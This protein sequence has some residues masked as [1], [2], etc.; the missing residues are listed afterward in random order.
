MTQPRSGQSDEVHLVWQGEYEQA[1]VVAAYT[2]ATDAEANVARDGG[3]VEGIELMEREPDWRPYFHAVA[4]VGTTG[5]EHDQ[6]P[7]VRQ[8]G[9]TYSDITNERVSVCPPLGGVPALW[10]SVF[11]MDSGDTLRCCQE[12]FDTLV[13]RR[14]RDG[15]LPTVLS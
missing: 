8:S 9:E 14:E 15:Q 7:D 12:K 5:A 13:E 1:M 2:D 10:L 11:G 4:Q 6:F 3:Y